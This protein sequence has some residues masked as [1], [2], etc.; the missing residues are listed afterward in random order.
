MTGTVRANYFFGKPVDHAEVIVKASARDVAVFDAGESK[1]ITDTDGAFHFDIR[2][3]DFFAGHPLSHGAALALIEA[4]VKDNAGHS[5]TRGESVTVSESPLLITAVP[6]GGTLIPGLENQVFVLASYPDGTPAQAEIRARGFGHG[7]ETAATDSGGVA[8]I[9][10]LGDEKKTQ[11]QIDAIDSEGNHTSVPLSL[12]PRAGSSQILLHLEKALYRPGDRI[13]LQ[14]WSTREKGSAYIDVVKDAQ[15][16]ATYD[17]DIVKSQATL[18]L[19]AT[20]GMSGTLA[21]NAYLFGRDGRPVG[22]HR[23]VFVQPADELKVE[24]SVDSP[25]YKP[26]K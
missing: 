10:W 1:G 11:I 5:E 15:T 20:P 7:E 6:E 14:V 9:H 24:T 3:P 17:L 2:L 22:D 23:L 18:D 26:G 25:I 13:H 19:T 21:F 8:I 12:E 16:I 4:T